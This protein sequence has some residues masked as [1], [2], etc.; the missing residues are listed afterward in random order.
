VHGRAFV[1]L[2]GKTVFYSR[3]VPTAKR[4]GAKIAVSIGQDE[5]RNILTKFCMHH[6][7]IGGLISG[8]LST[9]WAHI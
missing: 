1:T 7:V 2:L 6:Q 4:G 9:I 3:L 8:Y 5:V